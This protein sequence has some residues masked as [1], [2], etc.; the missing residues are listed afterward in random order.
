MYVYFSLLKKIFSGTKTDF[1]I[2]K[3]TSQAISTYAN[4]LFKLQKLEDK[5]RLHSLAQ[6]LL[7]SFL[8]LWKSNTKKT[9][10]NLVS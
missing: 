2:P 8:I 3:V 7:L 4:Y 5:E 1:F 10:R 9:L 6:R